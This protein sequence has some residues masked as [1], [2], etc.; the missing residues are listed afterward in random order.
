MVVYVIQIATPLF[1]A[2][3]STLTLMEELANSAIPKPSLHV[4]WLL[5]TGEGRDQSLWHPLLCTAVTMHLYSA[6]KFWSVLAHIGPKNSTEIPNII[7]I[8]V[9]VW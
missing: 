9:Y 3:P 8:F 5:S 2:S 1:P 4:S 7:H 6:G